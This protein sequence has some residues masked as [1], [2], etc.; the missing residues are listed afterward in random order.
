MGQSIVSLNVNCQA[1]LD[2]TGI[3]F[4]YTQCMELKDWVKAS[5]AAAQLSQEQLGEAVGRGK[6]TISQWEKGEYEPSYGQILMIYERTFRKVPLPNQ[7]G[8]APEVQAGIPADL[9]KP[10]AELVRT[11][12]LSAEKGVPDAGLNAVS[13]M[14]EI[15]ASLASIQSIDRSR[16]AEDTPSAGDKSDAIDLIGVPPISGVKKHARDAK[17]RRRGA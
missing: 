17:K 3:G 7:S 1:L 5:R 10:V 11:V 16:D 9:P 8:P 14:L 15:M 6:A 12:I 2:P 13:Q 4:L